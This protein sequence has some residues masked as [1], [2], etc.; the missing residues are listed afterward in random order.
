MLKPSAQRVLL[1]CALFPGPIS[2]A[3]IEVAAE[4]PTSECHLAIQDLQNLFLVPKPHF[5]EDLPRFGLNIN[6]RQLVKEVKGGTDLG[7]RVQRSIEVILGQASATPAYRGIIGQY[8]RQAVSLVKLDE[9]ADAETTLVNAL[10][11]YPE[12]AD[13]HGILGWVYKSWK[14]QPR[15]TDARNQFVRAAEL[16]SSKEDTYRHWWD[17]ERGQLEWTLAAEAAERGLEILSSSEQ[18]A[19]MAGLARSQLAKDL[20]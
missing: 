19:F 10:A 9:H 13:L 16:K 20:Y 1:T 15:P 8:I 6:T 12:S 4:V 2:L 18:L 3:E 11:R 7:N 14:P 17:M 5:I